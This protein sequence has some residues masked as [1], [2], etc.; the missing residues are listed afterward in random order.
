MSCCMAAASRRGAL[1]GRSRRAGHRR[2]GVS[3]Q[4]ADRRRARAR[5]AHARREGR[6][7]GLVRGRVVR[8]A[9]ESIRQGIA[10]NR[11]RFFVSRQRDGSALR[12]AFTALA[13]ALV[14]SVVRLKLLGALA[15]GARGGIAVGVA[16]AILFAL[17]GYLIIPRLQRAA[18]GVVADR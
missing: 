6:E 14:F 16:I 11:L 15:G 8:E 17:L 1:A 12:S 18:L 2:Q 10:A 3:A 9:V 7:V 13:L 4:L 5:G